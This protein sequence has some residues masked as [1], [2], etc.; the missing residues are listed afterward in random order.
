MSFYIIH[1]NDGTAVKTS[2]FFIITNKTWDTSIYFYYYF[3]F[4]IQKKNVS[5]VSKQSQSLVRRKTFTTESDT[6]IVR[7][8]LFV[9]ITVNAFRI[10]VVF[11]SVF[12]CCRLLCMCYV[13]YVYCSLSKATSTY[14]DL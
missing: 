11:L 9:P 5:Y 4:E 2:R 3:K 7:A 13:R 14:G 10:I 8:T 6:N 12:S 1:V